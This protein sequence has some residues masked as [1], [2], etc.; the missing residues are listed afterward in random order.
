MANKYVAAIGVVGMAVLLG[1][2]G[3]GGSA[4]GGTTPSPTSTAGA[5][6]SGQLLGFSAGAS[7]TSPFKNG[8]E[9]C[10]TTISN[11]ML[12]FNGKNLTSPTQNTAVSAPYSAWKFVDGA[13]TYEVIFN[14]SS[15]HEINVSNG[16]TFVGQFAKLPS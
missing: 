5:P 13:H 14:G 9:V 15:L 4:V 8:D 6:C 12:A 7:V 10:F 16:S 3:G 11:T 2:C 1:A